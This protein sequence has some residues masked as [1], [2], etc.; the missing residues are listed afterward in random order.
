MIDRLF[1]ADLPLQRNRLH[2]QLYPLIRLIFE[3][4]AEQAELEVLQR[5]YVHSKSLK[6]VADDIGT[7]I[8]D[9]IPTFLR[10][11]GTEPLQQEDDSAGEFGTLVESSVAGERAN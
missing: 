9:R 1:N 11:Q 8:T 5:C 7:V 10:R 6:V 2:A 3:D 4:I